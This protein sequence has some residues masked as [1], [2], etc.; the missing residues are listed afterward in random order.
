MEEDEMCGHRLEEGYIT[1]AARFGIKV[2]P[3]RRVLVTKRKDLSIVGSFLA[4]IQEEAV[5]GEVKPS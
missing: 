1:I 4:G 2:L 3:S 5:V